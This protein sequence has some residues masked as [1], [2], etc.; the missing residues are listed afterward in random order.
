M[1]INRTLFAE[2]K[3]AKKETQRLFALRFLWNMHC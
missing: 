1:E 3:Q 2:E